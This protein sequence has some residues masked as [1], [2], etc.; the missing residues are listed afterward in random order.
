MDAVAMVKAYHVQSVSCAYMA[1]MGAIADDQGASFRVWAPRPRTIE[2]VVGERQFPLKPAGG[3]WLEA[4]VDGVGAGARYCYVING[5]RRPDTA[6]RAQ[7]EGVH[8]AS[9]VVDPRR[10]EWKH[11]QPRRP[12]AEWVIYELH[13]GTFTREG[14]FDSV[15]GELPRLVDLGVNA[16]ELMP[17]RAFPG[18]RN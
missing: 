12:L 4:R 9:E 11:T 2:L 16:V 3:G 7:P 14:T 18:R 8:G 6:S 15:I 5:N 1:G 17:V 13:V 10:F